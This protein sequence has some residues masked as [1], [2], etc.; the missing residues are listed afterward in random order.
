MGQLS[1]RSQKYHGRLFRAPFLRRQ[2]GKCTGV[3]EIEP[4]FEWKD[5]VSAASR[6]S[7]TLGCHSSKGTL[8]YDHCVSA[9]REAGTSN[10]R[11]GK[12]RISGGRRGRAGPRGCGQ[13]PAL[14]CPGRTGRAVAWPR[15][16]RGPEK[17][18][19]WS[20][21]SPGSNRTDPNDVPRAQCPRV[22]SEANCDIP[23]S[24][25]RCEVDVRWWPPSG[26]Q[27]GPGQ[28]SGSCD[29]VRTPS[30]GARSWRLVSARECR[31]QT[32]S[33]PP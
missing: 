25:G 5:T 2:T 30:L 9:Q 26:A 1:S 33:R 14:R 17:H 10:V 12:Q 32:F 19:L 8:P 6:G 16:R 4:I 24:K 22:K 15:A 23:S 21:V 29:A 27:P 7:T 13:G 31:P 3:S 28:R 20:Q 11:G 18:Q